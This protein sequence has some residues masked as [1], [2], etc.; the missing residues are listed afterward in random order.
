[1]LFMRQICI[2]FLLLLIV[3]SGCGQTQ[4]TKNPNK[5][6]KIGMMLADY[7]LGDQSFNDGAFMGLIKARDELN[8]TVDY[9]DLHT[10]HSYTEGFRELIE[11]ENCDLIIGLGFDMV[12][13]AAEAAKKYPSKQFV[14]IDQK[15]DLPNVTSITFK[16]DEG[17]FLVGLIAG[18]KTN[19]NTVGFVGGMNVPLINRFKNGF[20]AGVKAVNPKANVVVA[21]ATDFGHPE[22][23][24]AI[25]RKMIEQ[26]KVDI[27][28]PAAGF[29]G[30][31]AL[32]E[33]AQKQK[34][35]I[36][37]DTDQ[38]FVAEKAVITSMVKNVD[39]AVY[40]VVK[41]FV[42][43]GG[44]KARDME[45]GIKENGVGM[46]PIRIISLN[47]REVHLVE[48]FTEQFKKGSILIR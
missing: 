16:E 23:G 43:K 31:G 26:K 47:P 17:S 9:R 27:I 6:I 40:N 10:S 28:F 39:V 7:G 45:L 42:E 33:A 8:I 35:A 37:V 12:K 22:M 44:L 41:E 34:Y 3:L 19:T 1:M 29:T 20:I 5:R 32:Q 15:I 48:S 24:R 46:A 14:F 30:L 21:Y 38:F 36:G 11:D 18:L 13:E 4:S 2:V 25:A